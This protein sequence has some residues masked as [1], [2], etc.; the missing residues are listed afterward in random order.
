MARSGASPRRLVGH[1]SAL[2]DAFLPSCNALHTPEG[3]PMPRA[4]ASSDFFCP[5][6]CHDLPIP[7]GLGRR[8]GPALLCPT[9]PAL[10]ETRGTCVKFFKLRE[11]WT[12][13]GEAPAGTL[14]RINYPHPAP[15]KRRERRQEAPN[16]L[17]PFRLGSAGSLVWCALWLGVCEP[18]WLPG[19]RAR[20]VPPRCLIYMETREVSV[21]ESGGGG[22]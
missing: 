4:R 15:P 9:G 6:S 19:G 14:R 22:D 11:G 8:P 21:C 20:R 3:R 7:R 5:V 18:S 17:L 16:F 13:S 12:R 1:P 2:K 10:E